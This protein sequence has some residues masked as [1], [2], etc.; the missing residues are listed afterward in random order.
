MTQIAHRAHADWASAKVTIMEYKN[1]SRVISGDIKNRTNT[2]E[3]I[4]NVQNCYCIAGIG[5]PCTIGTECESLFCKNGR[6]EGRFM[7]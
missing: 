1:N 7:I 6:C 2:D 3:F 4:I 5:A